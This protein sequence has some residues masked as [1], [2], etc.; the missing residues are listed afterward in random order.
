M[1]YF[2]N[3][4]FNPTYVNPSYYKTLQSVQIFSN[5]DVKIAKAVH[6]IHDLCDA[7][8]DMDEVVSKRFWG[9]VLLRWQK[10]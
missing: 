9:L 6:A 10:I 5:D 4:M 8:K 7:V 1:D 3:K 2:N